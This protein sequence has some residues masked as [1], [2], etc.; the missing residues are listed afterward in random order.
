MNPHERFQATLNHT[1]AD[2]LPVDLIWPRKETAEVLK[3]HFNT[4]SE[5]QVFRSLGIDFRWLSI[6][7]HY[8]EFARRINGRLEGEAPG[9]GAEYIFHDSR[10]F[11]DHWGVVQ[12]VGDDGKYLEYKE[13]PLNEKDSLE[14]WAAPEVIYP[15]ADEISRGVE[16]YRDFVTITEIEFPFKLAW[17]L[18]GYEHFMMLMHLNPETVELLYD[19]L[20]DFQTEKAVLAAKAGYDVVAVVGDIAGQTGLM[21]SPLMFERFDV[22][23]FRRMIDEVKKA[24]PRVKILYHSDGNM[25]AAIPM[26]IACG[27]DILNPIQ[28]AC[29][30]PVKIKKK[31]GN[32]LTF[33]GTISVQ[34]TIPNGTVKD[35]VNEVNE[36]IETI[37]YNGGLVISP[38]NSIPYDAPLENILA[39]YDT[40]LAYDYSSLR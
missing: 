10:T 31:Y 12:R 3:R 22:P 21:Y 29:M 15:S 33:H 1:L 28:S 27:I 35:V 25:E 18:C 9:A 39:V 19:R 26:L 38:E 5:E 24:N 36:R 8:P 2:R 37:G 11:E 17:H 34:D 30:D 32:S 14:G 20:Y 23:R 6:P 13:G 4:D 7:A 40:V 16:A